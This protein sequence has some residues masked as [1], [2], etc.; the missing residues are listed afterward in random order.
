MS[1]DKTNTWICPQCGAE[2]PESVELCPRCGF[3]AGVLSPSI[4]QGYLAAWYMRSIPRWIMPTFLLVIAALCLKVCVFEKD[5]PPDVRSMVLRAVSD[6]RSLSTAIEAY[7][8]E[9][10]QLIAH[11][12]AEQGINASLLENDPGRRIFTFRVRLTGEVFGTLTTPVAHIASYPADP[13]AKTPGTCLGYYTHLD[14]GYI[15]FSAGPDRDYDIDP[16]KDYD[17]LT[18]NP[19]PQ[20]LMKT[21]DPTNGAKSNGDLWWIKQ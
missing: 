14:K 5:S 2:Y 13:F 8:A 4:E 11:A 6:M 15:L 21:D 20:L 3:D 17:A 16:V 12:R 7:R 18:T 1:E 9:T 10:G 19:L